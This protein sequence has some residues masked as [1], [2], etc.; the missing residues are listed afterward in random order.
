MSV[1]AGEP[2]FQNGAVKGAILM[3]SLG[4]EQSAEVL[5]LISD[6]QVQQI[7]EAI[8]GLDEIT[9]EQTESVLSEF[10][11]LSGYGPTTRGGFGRARRL[12]TAAFGQEGGKQMVERL[13]RAPQQHAGGLA[14]L[15][16]TEPEL[17]AGFLASEHSQTIAVVLANLKKEKASAVLK[18][19]PEDVRAAAVLRLASMDMTSPELTGRIASV[20]EQ[21]VKML[22]DRGG[23]SFGGPR[24]V[25][26]LLNGIGGPLAEDILKNMETKDQATTSAIREMMF[27]FEDLA[28]LDANGL[29]ELLKRAD[30]KAMTVALK[31][32]SEEL[33]SSVF[34]SMSK[35]G[36]EMLLEDMEALGP[37]K[38]KEVETAQ[39]DLLALAKTL[40]N[41]GA[42]SLAGSETEQ[43]V[44]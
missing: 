26:E 12:L 15:E 32:A 21:K 31:G 29:K 5:K 1:A 24:A 33:R 23:E 20:L 11:H 2:A 9:P 38:I 8:A 6:E 30:K 7:T 28:R 25:A 16:S 17:L 40:E 18:H 22:G 39:K 14:Y 43:Y 44:V 3:L 4:Y 41:E 27:V 42:L 37:V 35:R 19:L 10:I 36:A 13:P 34:K